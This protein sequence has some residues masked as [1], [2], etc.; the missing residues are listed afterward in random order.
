MNYFLGIT[1][2]SFVDYL[3]GLTGFIPLVICYVY[4][5]STIDDLANYS[6]SQHN[7]TFELIVLIASIIFSLICVGILTKIAKDELDLEL[8]NDGDNDNDNASYL[9]DEMESR[10]E[11]AG[12]EKGRRRNGSLDKSHYSRNSILSGKNKSLLKEE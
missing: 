12:S 11:E 10:D 8:N 4:L 6:F 3:T 1:N 2:T 9:T 5:G 7:K